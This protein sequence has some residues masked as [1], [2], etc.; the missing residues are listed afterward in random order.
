MSRKKTTAPV[1]PPAKAKAKAM[2]L[3]MLSSDGVAENYHDFL[4]EVEA[5]VHDG[6]LSRSDCDELIAILDEAVDAKDGGPKDLWSVKSLRDDLKSNV[7]AH[8]AQPQQPAPATEPELE[9]KLPFV[10][11]NDGFLDSSSAANSVQPANSVPAHYSFDPDLPEPE[12]E[13]PSKLGARLG[14]FWLAVRYPLTVEAAEALLETVSTQASSEDGE[15]A[16]VLPYKALE[17]LVDIINKRQQKMLEAAETATEDEESA[18]QALALYT[19]GLSEILETYPLPAGEDINVW[20]EI[21]ETMRSFWGGLCIGVLC[22]ML[23]MVVVFLIYDRN[24]PTYTAAELAAAKQAA[25]AEALAS[26]YS[27]VEFR[28]AIEKATAE[29]KEEV[30]R[31]QA[32]AL[33]KSLGKEEILVSML[34]PEGLLDFV[35]LAAYGSAAHE[36]TVFLHSSG[37]DAA[38]SPPAIDSTNPNDIEIIRQLLG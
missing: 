24:N 15:A 19:R 28:A 20:A 8:Y 6:R 10:F 27:E 4:K 31:Q 17:K 5:G 38:M 3:T 2:L 32:M 1:I 18:I 26:S 25:V 16:P 34:T 22:A 23:V 7:A 35:W 14:N 12:P 13:T 36:A 29:G 9:P 30:I 33:A 37:L 11:I 21:K